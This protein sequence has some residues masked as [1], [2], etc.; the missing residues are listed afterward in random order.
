VKQRVD[1]VRG[2]KILLGVTGGIAAY[3]AA[4]LVRQLTRSGASV[5][6]VMTRSATEFVT[7]LTFSALSNAPV[8]LDLWSRD[9]T[10]D[11]KV[12]TRHINLATWC[13]LMLIAPASA[14]TLAKL[15]HGYADNLLTVLALACRKRVVLAPTMDADM[16]VNEATQHNL[17]VLRERGYDVIPPDVG[18]H[19]SGLKGPGRLPEVESIIAAVDRVLGGSDQDLKGKKVVVSAGP[20]QEAIDPVRFIG[21]HSSGK[22]GFAIAREAAARGADVTLVAGP[23]QRETPRHVKRVDVTSADD[24]AKALR[25]AVGRADVLVMAAAVADY[26]PATRSRSK[27]KKSEDDLTLRLQR[28]PDVL[29]NLAPSLKKVRVKVGF[30]LETHNALANARAKLRK[31]SLDLVVLNEYNARNRVFGSDTNA[32]T[33][34]RASGHTRKYPSRQKTEVARLLVDTIKEML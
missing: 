30:A 3:K 32:V 34:I 21:N 6:V 9:Q 4:Y 8:G 20:T 17:S 12:G 11:S 7:P 15:A 14:N 13:D 10:T 22:M 1:T 24:M 26:A 18:E 5:R 31:K 2:S 23:V 16:Y 19:A 29:A 27:I 33:F 28:T 25:R